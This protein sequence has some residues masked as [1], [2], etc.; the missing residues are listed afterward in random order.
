MMVH[1]RLEEP[2]AEAFKRLAKADDRPLASYVARV[3]KQHA[4][5]VGAYEEPEEDRAPVRPPER[6]TKG[7]KP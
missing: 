3:L 2:I 1:I 4:I 6:K 5:A 7:R